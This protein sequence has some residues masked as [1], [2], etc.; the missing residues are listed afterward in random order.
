MKLVI[1]RRGMQSRERV[2]FDGE[3]GTGK[4]SNGIHQNNLEGKGVSL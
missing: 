4:E 3:E 1:N 2:Y